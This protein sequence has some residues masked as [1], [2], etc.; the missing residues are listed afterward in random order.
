M[1]LAAS[2]PSCSWRAL[3]SFEQEI[4]FIL[5]DEDQKCSMSVRITNSTFSLCRPFSRVVMLMRGFDFT[6]GWVVMYKGYLY[7]FDIVNEILGYKQKK[8]YV[9]SKWMRKVR[10]FIISVAVP[11]GDPIL[12]SDLYLLSLQ[13]ENKLP[14]ST[15]PRETTN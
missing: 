8:P 2:A 12:L 3:A 1:F 4:V 14:P 10:S 11:F 6:L 13:I 15:A 5:R 9:P 7:Q